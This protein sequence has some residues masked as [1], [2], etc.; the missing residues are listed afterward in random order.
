ME[1]GL[2]DIVN[3]T[4]FGIPKEEL[5]K[6]MKEKQMKNFGFEVAHGYEIL[7]GYVKG[8]ES[9]SDAETKILNE[10]WDDI[11]DEYDTDIYTE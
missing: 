3:D 11:I 5:N 7:K 2:K 10:L 8:C 9:K 1:F 6:F 4:V